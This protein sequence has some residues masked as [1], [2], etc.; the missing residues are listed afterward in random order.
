MEGDDYA[1]C[2]SI[3]DAV[4]R[5]RLNRYITKYVYDPLIA[6]YPD[7]D[8]CDYQGRSM[9]AWNKETEYDGSPMF[10]GGNRE[11]AGNNT[12]INF[13]L[14]RPSNAYY[15]NLSTKPYGFNSAYYAET[16][17]SAALWEFN[18]FKN[19]Y[20]AADGYNISTWIAYYDY[21][22]GEMGDETDAR[23]MSGTAYYSEVLFHI[24]LLDPK[25]FIGFIV[26][27]ATTDGMYAGSGEDYIRRVRVAS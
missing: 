11:M 20:K 12:N 16:P 15:E 7:A 13:Y 6:F 1:R 23:V 21:H 14:H 4:M 18:V 24:G 8:V 26:P 3:W 17:F 19:L 22:S 10:V 5:T 9:D 27:G 25:P 2:R